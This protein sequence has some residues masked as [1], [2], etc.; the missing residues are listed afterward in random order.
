MFYSYLKHI[1]KL[2]LIC[3]TLKVLINMKKHL[4]YLA[5]FYNKKGSSF[6]SLFPN[7]KIITIKLNIY[8]I[9]SVDYAELRFLS[10]AHM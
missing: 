7:I 2:N 10:L 9:T 6:Y 1:N 5:T 3:N 8:F 4:L